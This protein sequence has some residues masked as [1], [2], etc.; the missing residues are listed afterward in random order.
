M[1]FYIFAYIS[2]LPVDFTVGIP[3]HGDSLFTQILVAFLVFGLS[4]FLMAILALAQ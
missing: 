4:I 2:E 1:T 3:K